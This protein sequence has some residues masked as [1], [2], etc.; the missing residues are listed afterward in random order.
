[1]NSPG[2]PSLEQR[3]QARERPVGRNP[4]MFQKWRD[5]LFLHWEWE[6]EALQKTLPAGLQVDLFDGKAYL[7][8]V[9]FSM[10]GIR[11]WWSPPF[12]GISNFL[13]LNLRTYVFDEQG[14]PGV[15]FYSLDANRKLAV[16][17][18]RTFFHLPYFDA[19]MTATRDAEGMISYSSHRAGTGTFP[20]TFHYQA[21]Q[22]LGDAV[23][24]TLEFFLLERY[25]LFAWNAKKQELLSGK[26]HH[27]PYPMHEAVVDEWDCYV[28]Q[29]NGF[30]LPTRPPDHRIFSHGVDVEVFGVQR[31]G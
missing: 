11:P 10:Q 9:P 16:R 6:P 24:G 19:R 23:P 2:I 1:M 22:S 4:V 17:I 8:V 13:E 20:N 21:G 18:A 14:C 27:V 26:V 30:P 25:M 5:L 12:P 3:L 28:M 15:W 31:C 29:E 7:G